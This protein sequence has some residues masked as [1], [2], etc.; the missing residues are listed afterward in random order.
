MEEGCE[1]EHIDI[2][3]FFDEFAQA[4]HRKGMGFRLA[5]VECD[6]VFHTLPGVGH[7][8]V[9]MNRI[10]HDIGKEA[11][12]ILME[13]SG[14][15]GDD[16]TT[17]AAAP[18]IGG[19][20]LSGRTVDNFPPAPDI[21]AG[22]R[23]QHIRIK[24]LHQGNLQ[25][26]ALGGIERS[27]KIH[28]LDFVGILPRPVVVLA[29]GVVSGINFGVHVLQLLRKIRAVAV[30]EGVRAPAFHQLQRTGDNVHIGGN[31]YKS[32]CFFHINRPFGLFPAAFAENAQSFR[33]LNGYENTKAGCLNGC[34]FLW[35]QY[36][37]CAGGKQQRFL[38]SFLEFLLFR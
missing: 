36:K 34:V 16:S 33:L 26:G 3:M 9:H 10:P 25:G 24:P 11:D 6:L 38:S 28:L 37:K 27:H 30:P 8:V 4:L 12:R 31:G 13:G 32:F 35:L 21:V 22:V 15:D 1:A 20:H 29:G 2:G 14:L 19:Y 18:V 23:S 17:L 5:D 7:C